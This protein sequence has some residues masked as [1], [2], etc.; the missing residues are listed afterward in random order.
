MIPNIEQWFRIWRWPAGLIA[1]LLLWI[2]LVAVVGA[3]TLPG[4]AA[5]QRTRTLPSVTGNTTS[6]PA[7]ASGNANVINM[8][9]YPWRLIA[10]VTSS[11]SNT[12]I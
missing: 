10:I 5:V 1:G 2:A 9:Y 4:E 6:T 12:A 7:R 3:S 8:V 11:P